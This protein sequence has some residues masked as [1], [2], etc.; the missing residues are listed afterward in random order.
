MVKIVSND[1][2]PCKM[3]IVLLGLNFF[4]KSETNIDRPNDLIDSTRLQKTNDKDSFFWLSARDR[5]SYLTSQLVN[6]DLYFR[7]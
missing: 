2:T 1:P 7:V 3:S 6:S 4:S 5:K